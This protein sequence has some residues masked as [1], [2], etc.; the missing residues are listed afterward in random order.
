MLIRGMRWAFRRLHL[1]PKL[2]RRSVEQAGLPTPIPSRCPS[3]TG[4]RLTDAEVM[5]ITLPHKM[6]PLTEWFTIIVYRMLITAEEI[7]EHAMGK[8]KSV[9]PQVALV[10]ARQIINEYYSELERRGIR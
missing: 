3:V 10:N 5:K 4:I 9:S 8:N 2:V 6:L 7:V 1:V